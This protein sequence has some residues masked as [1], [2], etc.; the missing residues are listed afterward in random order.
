MLEHNILRTE[1]TGIRTPLVADFVARLIRLARVIL[2]E[3][4]YALQARID[5][6][7]DQSA[8]SVGPNPDDSSPE[9]H[10]L[11]NDD[12]RLFAHAIDVIT[13]NLTMVVR[14]TYLGEL[15]ATISKL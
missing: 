15:L 10:L 13:T 14:L 1:T 12:Q 6:Q 8:T 4:S 5:R 9:V 3:T 7:E 11:G 2:D